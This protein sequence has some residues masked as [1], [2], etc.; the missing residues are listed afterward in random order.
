MDNFYNKYKSYVHIAILA[1][2]MAVFMR[3]CSL[4][5]KVNTLIENQNQITLQLEDQDRNWIKQLGHNAAVIQGFEDMDIYFEAMFIE[6]LLYED[7]I[8]K[9]QLTIAQLSLR[10]QQLREKNDTLK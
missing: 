4:N 9:R 10:L 5:S 7:A 3:G 2:C 1:I 8:D 6:Y